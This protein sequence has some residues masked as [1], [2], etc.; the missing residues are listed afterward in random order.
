MKAQ[1][2]SF[3]YPLVPA[4]RNLIP[5]ALTLFLGL[6]G[7]ARADVPMPG[8]SN[9]SA[10]PVIP[11]TL[12]L[13][14]PDELII[15]APAT[16]AQQQSSLS[17]AGQP[18]VQTAPAIQ[19]Q[20]VPPIGAVGVQTQAP[21]PVAV[22][23]MQ[24]QPLV[25]RPSSG[26]I[27]VAPI[28]TSVPSPASLGASNASAG[29]KPAAVISKPA[30]VTTKAASTGIAKSADATK[31]LPDNGWAA[32]HK[33]GSEAIDS[34]RYGVAERT[35]KQAITKGVVFGDKDLRYAKSLDELARL[36]TIRGRFGEAEPLLEEALRVKESAIDDESGKIIPSLGH[37]ISFYLENGTASKA[38]PLAD[39]LL[40]FVEGRIDES[41]NRA[42]GPVTLKKGQPLTGWA[43]QA[44]PSMRDPIIEWAIT[45]D[46]LGNQFSAKKDYEMADRLYKA[47]LDIKETVLGK[48]HLSLANSFDSIGT[49]CLDKNEDSE[50]ENMY[51]YA[52]EHTE[53]VLPDDYGKIF[54]RMDKL[55]K[56]LIKEKKYEEAE[57]LYRKALDFW[58]K[59]PSRNGSEA[60]LSFALGNV[61]VMEKKYDEA[62]PVLK[63]ALR[64]AE[65]YYGPNSISLMP[66]L[67]RNAD[68]MYYMGQNDQRIQFKSRAESIAG[69]TSTVPQ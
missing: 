14:V 40:N 11:H 21:G 48:E 19:R 38:A 60:R 29:A 59:E 69:V 66:Y 20:P 1:Y 22:P 34:G 24:N 41:R 25:Q 4:G 30:A 58:K 65:E 64:L 46:A 47:A 62:Q 57:A 49:I 26:Q 35:L 63:E 10:P 13:D 7:A 17:T 39:Q 52:L 37:L 68:L 61:L 43:G 32:L 56:C 23:A 5:L 36:Y 6:S 50:A 3:I 31:A 28:Q 51:R 18:V 12:P 55:A 44:A 2:T 54:P 9:Q 15:P 16:Q 67:Q 45:C 42:Q 27:P 33:A 53:R 8:A